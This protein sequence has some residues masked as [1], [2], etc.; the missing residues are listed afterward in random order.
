[1]ITVYGSFTGILLCVFLPPIFDHFIANEAT[2]SW[3]RALGG[4]ALMT[5]LGGVLPVLVG[6]SVYLDWLFVMLAV[7]VAVLVAPVTVLSTFFILLLLKIILPMLVL[8][9]MSRANKVK[10]P[11]N[12]FLSNMD[13]IDWLKFIAPMIIGLVTFDVARKISRKNCDRPRTRM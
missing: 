5:G 9:D 13:Y 12:M 3:K 7:A 10:D 8:W 4:Y 1:M 2:R 6:G 11:L